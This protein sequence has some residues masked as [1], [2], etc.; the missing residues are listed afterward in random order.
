MA[1]LGRLGPASLLLLPS[2]PA[3]PKSPPA[4]GS[5]A[6]QPVAGPGCPQVWLGQGGLGAFPLQCVKPLP[7][8]TAPS[9]FQSHKAA[10]KNEGR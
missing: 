7:P 10:E 3:A 5:L 9:A 4:Q 2:Q 1:W 8:H 6:P